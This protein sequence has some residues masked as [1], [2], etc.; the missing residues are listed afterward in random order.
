MT[1][2]ANRGRESTARRR[3]IGVRFL[4]ILRRHFPP[5]SELT[6]LFNTKKVK[7][8]YS[9]CPSMNAIISSHNKKIIKPKETEARA[10]CNCKGGVER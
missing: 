2:G 6:S 9:F 4:T 8:S 3:N 7:L 5:S 1:A 10:G